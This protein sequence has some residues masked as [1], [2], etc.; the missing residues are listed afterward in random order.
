MDRINFNDAGSRR[1]I[2]LILGEYK[3][4]DHARIDWE[5]DG[6]FDPDEVQGMVYFRLIE[7]LMAKVESLEIGE[8]DDN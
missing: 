3:K 4:T 8:G 1:A 2:A 6:V 7:S 5:E